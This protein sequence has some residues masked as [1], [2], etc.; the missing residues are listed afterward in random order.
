[1]PA[2]QLAPLAL[3]PLVLRLWRHSRAVLRRVRHGVEHI[4]DTGALPWLQPPVAVDVMSPM[5]Y[6]VVTQR[7]VRGERRLNNTVYLAPYNPDWTKHFSLHAKH[8]RDAL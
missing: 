3:E 6:V 5:R 1:M 4:F 7:L 8:I 2:L